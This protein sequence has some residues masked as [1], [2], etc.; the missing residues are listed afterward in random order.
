MLDDAALET[1]LTDGESDRV[2]FK[3]SHR[4][5]NKIAEAICAFANDMPD[6]GRA[7]VV[8]IG[9]NDDGTCA[10]LDLTNEVLSGLAALRDEGNILPLPSMTVQKRVLK[11]CEVVVIEV[12][13][14]DD[15][16]VRF[17]GHTMIRV[18]PRR[19]IATPSEERRLIERRQRIIQPFDAEQVY[20]SSLADLD[21]LRFQRE[22]LPQA[23]APEILKDD[24]RSVEQHLSA[25]R[26]T[27]PEN[28]PTG[29][30]LLALGCKPRWF[31]PGAYV[32]FVRFHGPHYHSPIVN[33]R[34]IE[35]PLPDVVRQL[36]EVIH[37]N[38]TT[39]VTDGE[40]LHL[41]RPDYPVMA[42]RELVI[43]AVLHRSY[44]KGNAPARFYWFSDFIEI[45]NPGGPF[46][47]VTQVNFGTPGVTAYRNPHVADVLKVLGYVHRFG[48][49]IPLVRKSLA[50]NGNPPPEFQVDDQHVRV[51]LR[52]RGEVSLSEP[53]QIG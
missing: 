14:A 26:M 11:G 30:G 48:V 22:Y 52:P 24:E 13:P 33:E 44:E 27:T 36:D 39:Q 10:C 41:W 18:G 38:L 42:L 45:I 37:N 50:E 23:V 29:V 32:Q 47:P 8:F 5:R 7:G 15:P 4:D 16:P 20:G 2:E 21:V 49:G 40:N 25:L 17:R 34:M 35:G 3:A 53:Q 28:I 6:H 12:Q 1:L 51:I 31:F 9:V 19:A 46:E 43:N